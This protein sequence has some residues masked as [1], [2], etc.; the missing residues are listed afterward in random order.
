MAPGLVFG[1]VYS[2]RGVALSM[3]L[4]QEIGR[5]AAGRRT[6]EQMSLPVTNMKPVPFHPIAVQVANRMHGWDRFQDRS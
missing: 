5:W 4:G 6:N 3:S 2:G 1:G